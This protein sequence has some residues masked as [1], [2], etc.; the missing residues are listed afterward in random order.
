MKP[1]MRVKFAP[2]GR[3][4]VEDAAWRLNDVR[5]HFPLIQSD[6]ML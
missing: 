2:G 6:N 4:D 5:A 3:W 1:N